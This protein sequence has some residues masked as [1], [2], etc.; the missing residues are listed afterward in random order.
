M[1]RLY[2]ERLGHR[3]DGIAPGPVYVPGALPGEEV[4]GE[5]V[6]GV[7]AAPRIVTP[8]DQRVRPPC[9]H[10]RSCGGCQLQHATQA[11]TADWKTEVVQQ[12]LAAHGLEAPLRG[13]VTSPPRSRRR[14]VFSAR[15][16]K[17]GALAGFH[18][19]RS[20]VIVAVP[21]CQLVRPAIAA[22]LPLVEALAVA[23][24]SRKGEISALVTDSLAGLDV[25]V[26]GGKP[27]DAALR[28]ALAD[29]AREYDLARLSWDGESLLRRAPAQRMGRAQVTP[30]PGAFLQATSEG[31]AALLSG[32]EEALD[33]ATRIAD[34]FAGC[35]TFSLPLAETAPVHAVEGDAAMLAALDHGW[36]N[37]TGLKQ[38]THEARDLF[39]NPL[40]PDELKAF[41]AVVIDPPRAGAAAQVAQIAE[42]RVPRV[43]HVSCNPVTFARDS[44]A[45]VAGG[46]ALEWVQVVDQF[47]WSTHVELVAA[48]RFKG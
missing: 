14:A 48:L 26:T 22:A 2:I 25:S 4:E 41:D 13:I 3:G 38:V 1:E 20:D 19:K 10:A 18:M 45:L 28:S 34:L 37:A 27:I 24:A 43:A 32:V 47:R 40:L 36:R 9:S 16:T 8:S 15:R 46:Y 30:P 29:L 44:A 42:A 35:G 31:E 39:R 21:E 12:A 23:G 17:K 6:D 11:F 5:T 33:G 7:M